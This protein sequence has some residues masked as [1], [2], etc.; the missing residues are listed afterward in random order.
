MIPPKGPL[1]QG[2]G[3]PEPGIPW[4]D[5]RHQTTA[6]RERFEE[7]LRAILASGAFSNGPETALFEEEWSRYVKVRHAIGVSDGTTAILLLLRAA[8][9]GAGDEVLTSPTSYFATAEAI[10]L[11]G[12][13]PTFADIDPDTG[14]LDPSSV[15]ANISAN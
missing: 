3:M 14:N 5:L 11:S 9:I 12:A 4:I 8:E 1:S 2:G 10:A 7:S 13:R 6:I 15:E